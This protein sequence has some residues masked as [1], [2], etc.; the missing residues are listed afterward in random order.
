MLAYKEISTIGT[1][2][3]LVATSFIMGVFYANQAYDFHVLFNPQVAQSH[4]D[5]SL[6]HYQTLA[7]T[8]GAVLGGLAFVTFVGLVGCLIRIYKPNPDLQTFEYA[9]VV[10]YVIGICLFITNIKT[11]VESAVS[12]NWGEVTQNQGVAVIGSSNIILLLVFIGV[13][14]LQAGLW[15]SNWEYQVRLDKFLAEEAAANKAEE[16][17]PKDKEPKKQK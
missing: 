3:I 4:F 5:N 6:R 2:L 11:G 17:Q 1:G 9:S 13:L 10:M 12:G 7:D 8:P 16:T 15:Y 14:V